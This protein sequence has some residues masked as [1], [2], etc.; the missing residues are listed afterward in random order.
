MSIEEETKAPRVKQNIRG[1]RDFTG[2][3]AR[4]SMQTD[5]CPMEDSRREQL[6]LSKPTPYLRGV[7]YDDFYSWCLYIDS[8]SPVARIINL[9]YVIKLLYANVP[10]YGVRFDD[11]TISMAAAWQVS[12]TLDPQTLM[13]PLKSSKWL[14]QTMS[15]NFHASLL[16]KVGGRRRSRSQT[17]LWR[18]DPICQYLY[19]RY[20][21]SKLLRGDEA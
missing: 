17:S 18:K 19:G 11:H 6:S 14:W 16:V 7:E 3:L 21:G 2:P 10:G 15:T 9:E 1:P 8:A 12:Q 20:K 4:Y 13:R 5:R